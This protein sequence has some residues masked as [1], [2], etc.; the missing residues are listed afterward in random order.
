MRVYA[1]DPLAR[2]V[3]RV[4]VNGDDVTTRCT[5][6][7]T[8]EQW[9]DLH[10]LDDK[11]KVQLNEAR[12]GV[13]TER[14]TGVIVVQFNNEERSDM[15][16]RCKFTCV[17][18]VQQH[19]TQGAEYTFAPLYDTETP[20]DQRFSKSTPSGQIVLLVTNEKVSYE[21]GKAYYF[22]SVPVEAAAE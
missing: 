14:V 10:V 18:K 4:L 19:Y 15:R 1:G 22:D 12:D 8:D 3:R 17:K 20:E 13:L 16:V 21:L 6:F 9:A 2:A 5:A 7:D 11:G